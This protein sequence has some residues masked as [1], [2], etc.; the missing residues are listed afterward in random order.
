MKKLLLLA[1]GLMCVINT[2]AQLKKGKKVAPSGKD[3]AKLLGA[4]VAQNEKFANQVPTK[5]FVATTNLNMTINVKSLQ[6][7]KDLDGNIL[8]IK[9]QLKAGVLSKQARLSPEGLAKQYLQNLKG[10]MSVKNPIDEFLLTDN[11][12]DDLSQTHYRLQ[13]TYQNVPVYGAE[14]LLH[15]EKNTENF[16]VNGRFY[17]TPQLATVTPTF[18]EKNIADL[19]KADI[20]NYAIVRMMGTLE[21][22]LLKYDQPQANL[23][24]YHINEDPNQERLAWQVMVRP[25]FIERW[26]YMV[27]AQTGEI[28]SKVNHTCT[29]D[30]VASATAT[31]LNGV[32]RAIQTYSYNGKY[33][34]LDATRT[35]AQGKAIF[36]PTTSS[37][38][39]DPIGA[40]LTLD[41]AGTNESSFSVR[42][43]SSSNNT[44]NNPTAVSAHYNAAT[45]YEY[46][47]QKHQRTSL[48]GKGGTIYSIINIADDDGKGMDNA[49][50][51]GEFMGYGSGRSYFKPLAG[52]LDVAGHEMTH[53]VVENT[54]NLQYSGQSGAINE[55]MADIFGVLIDSDDWT[56]GEDV[57]Q[58]SAYPTGALRSMSNP[59]NG[60]T[61]LNSPGYQPKNMSQYYTGS[62][63]NYGVHINSGISNYA[64]YLFATNT[65][66]GRDKAGKVYYRALTT[67]LTKTSKFA[68]LRVAVLKSCQD[69]YGTG[70]E[71]QALGSAFDA[72]GIAGSGG[73]TTPTP[74]PT[75]IP[76]NAGSEYIL[77]YDPILKAL[78]VSNT[79]PK[80]SSDFREIAKNII[81]SHKP[82]VT[83]NGQY[84]Y[85]VTSDFHIKRI[86]L[87]TTNPSIETVSTQAI[88]DNV[89]VSKDGKRLAALT[90]EADKSV[91]IFDLVN[92]KSK[93]FTLYNPTYSGV[94]A[95]QVQYA[96]GVE[97][98]LSGEYVV[99]DAYNTIK[100]ADGSTSEY[101][102][103]GFLEAFNLSQNT[104][105]NGIIQKLFTSLDRG[106]SIGNPSFSKNSTDVIVFDYFS[107][108]EEN[109]IL[110][111]STE[112]G[113]VGLVY[114]NNDTGYPDYSSK[115]NKIIFN[116]T[117]SNKNYTASINIGTDK[118]SASGSS[119]L[120]I[121]DSQWAVWFTQ[122]Q[123]SLPQK[124]VQTITFTPISD[125]P[126]GVQ[127]FAISAT[128]SSGLSVGYAVAS[129]NATI[130][131]NILTVL[132]TGTI[133]ITAFQEGNSQYLRATP[134]SITFNVANITASEKDILASQIEISPNPTKGTMVVTMPEGLRSEQIE[135][136][137]LSGAILR[138]TKTGYYGNIAIDIST[139]PSGMYL[140]G[141]KTETNQVWKKVVKE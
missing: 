138:Q 104:F 137:T 2:F 24:I 125:K 117:Q 131:G 56:L 13:Q 10:L 141:I 6:V 122:G 60:G 85:F 67:Y 105:G 43:V 47:K 136:Q 88:W 19:V 51:N 79:A 114:K 92:N 11:Q 133:T 21:K 20:K 25:N 121:Q 3:Y 108:N 52:G 71:Y 42:Q 70:T 112:T 36:K 48:N 55:S 28:L 35:D 81:V 116:T 75:T 78:Y 83:D 49:Y 65:N 118:I 76:T 106:E 128:A 14:V 101:W 94:Q 7:E 130:S 111:T 84:A 120:L 90:K 95:G 38:P 96:D 109:Y 115:D 16:V 98:D 61:S 17:P 9:G 30:G 89:A 99:Y 77:S 126:V 80:A 82:S 57:V 41:A 63:D 74:P 73:N 26:Y 97:W 44:W 68:D 103:V 134:V 23:V 45:A 32:Q 93:K 5:T 46:Y 72:V 39:N 31:D 29:A 123:R 12:T 18:T 100:N 58:K 54:A 127:P 86:N 64:F 53:G 33:Y 107:P 119:S 66:V 1:F 113:K 40:L 129:G 22:N 139:L 102:D 59:N 124:T 132:G 27:D 135:I 110:A 62:E 69:L 87:T 37:M 34:L 4:E 140:L 15:T 91:Y 50:W 8:M